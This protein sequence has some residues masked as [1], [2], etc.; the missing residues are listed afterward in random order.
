MQEQMTYKEKEAWL[1][2]AYELRKERP[3]L[4]E[5]WK[6]LQRLR[7]ICTDT[8]VK[9]SGSGGRSSGNATETKYVRLADAS[10]A[11]YQQVRA[12]R[13]RYL[14]VK[15]EIRKAINALPVA[16]ERAVLTA[17]FLRFK[18]ISEIARITHYSISHVKLLKRRGIEHICIKNNTL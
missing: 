18:K 2:R 17:R 15:A 13:E 12:E 10:E 7:D 11:Y 6:E 14:S 8:S 4:I 1:N 5:E 3:A 16:A 9:L